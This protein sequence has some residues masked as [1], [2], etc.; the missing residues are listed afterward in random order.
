MAYNAQIAQI[1]LS[2]Q[3]LWQLAQVNSQLHAQ[4]AAAAFQANLGQALFET[5]RMAKRVAATVP[6]D[7]FAAAILSHS[8]LKRIVGLRPELFSDV[9][10]KRSWADAYQT[11][12]S[13]EQ[14]GQMEPSTALAVNQYFRC[15]DEWNRFRAKLGENPDTFAAHAAADA[16]RAAHRVDGATKKLIIGCGGS[17]ALVLLAI[18]LST[19]GS[20]ASGLVWLIAICG[21]IASYF[22]VK[23]YMDAGASN[24]RFQAAAQEAERILAQY[25]AFQSDPNGGV[26]LEHAWRE[27]PLLFQEPIPD[28]THA[29]HGAPGVV[30]TFVERRL[31]ERQIVVTRCK[32]CQQM[33]PVDGP[34]CQHCGAPAFAS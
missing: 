17:I 8:W 3:Q 6:Q 21:A 33:T 12:T 23:E 11:L 20:S 22:F 34:S 16:Q 9:A 15:M 19:V 13:T 32:F 7:L 26:F 1:H 2:Q 14:R 29:H 5:E 25:K 4:Q 30:Q 10:S 18:I 28:A 27:H 24:Q 31:V